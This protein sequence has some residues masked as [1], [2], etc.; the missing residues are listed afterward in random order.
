[1]SPQE[2]SPRK[3]QLPYLQGLHVVADAQAM[4]AGLGSRGFRD[5]LL[6]LQ[7]LES[8]NGFRRN[9]GVMVVQNA[10]NV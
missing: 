10:F 8:S 4:G 9:F 2:M 7:R 3:A 5:L 1:M 6:Q